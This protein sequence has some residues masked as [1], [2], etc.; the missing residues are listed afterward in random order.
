MPKE[1]EKKIFSDK[2]K[3][4]AKEERVPIIAP[5]DFKENGG[6]ISARIIFKGEEQISPFLKLAVLFRKPV[7]FHNNNFYIPNSSELYELRYK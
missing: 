5:A 4:K 1:D 3:N 7:V 6:A 2:V